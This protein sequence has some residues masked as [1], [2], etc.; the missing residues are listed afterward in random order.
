VTHDGAPVAGAVV[1]LGSRT[2]GE[3]PDL[4]PT[5]LFTRPDGS[6]SLDV[7][8]DGYDLVVL[9]TTDDGPL[10]AQ[11][12]IDL[13]AGPVAPLDLAMAPPAPADQDVAAVATD[14]GALRRLLGPVPALADDAASAEGEE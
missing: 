8:R 5:A 3:A 11:A 10:V 1:V 12:T 6:F 2:T 14:A 4:D 13:A 9:G 7:P